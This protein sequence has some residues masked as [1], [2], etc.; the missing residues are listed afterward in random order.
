MSKATEILVVDDDPDIRLTLKDIL[1]AHG[2]AVRTAKNGQEA[3][4][5][6][7]V[8]VPDLMILDI[9]MTTDMEGFEVAYKIKAS[10][11]L[12]RMPII[13]LTGFL[14]KVRAN[15]PEEFVEIMEEEWPAKWLFEKPVEPKKLL[16][17][18]KD[19]LEESQ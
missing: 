19:V 5:M 10:P 14:E 11:R 17:K 6:L 2:Y 1:E 3:L 7:N 16:A 9:M 12:S 15:G 8:W 4:E 18:I 13:M